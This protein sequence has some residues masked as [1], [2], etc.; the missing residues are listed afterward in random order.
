M[1]YALSVRAAIAAVGLF[2]LAG[3]AST[4]IT[5]P[6]INAKEVDLSQGREVTGRSCGFQLL[7]VIPIN[8]N[9][10]FEEAYDQLKGQAGR[11]LMANLRIEES[12]TYAFVGTVYC[13]KLMATAYPRLAAPVPKREAPPATPTTPATPAT[14]V[15]EAPKTL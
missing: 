4:P 13:T 12:W 1:R 8:I 14:P 9:G 7:L 15:N 6:A 5:L 10:R 3:C 2:V 11:D